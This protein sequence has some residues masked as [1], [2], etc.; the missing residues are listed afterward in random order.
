[1]KPDVAAGG[2]TFDRRILKATAGLAL[3]LA[4]PGI[5][6]ICYYASAAVSPQRAA[7][8]SPVMLAWPVALVSAAALL[9]PAPR[10][11]AVRTGA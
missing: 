8:A 7:W 3:V 1:M 4:V 11:R 5:A 2:A 9:A 10:R 6:C